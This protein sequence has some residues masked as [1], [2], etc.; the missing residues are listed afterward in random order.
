MIKKC[1]DCDKCLFK[2]EGMFQ[3]MGAKIDGCKLLFY[4]KDYGP[5]E[6]LFN[7]YEVEN[8]EHCKYFVS[9]TNCLKLIKSILKEDFRERR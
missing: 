7:S 9:Q 2:E 8:N 1:I 5:Y 3:D 6:S 4:H